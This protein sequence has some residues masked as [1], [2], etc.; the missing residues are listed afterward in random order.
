MAG[1]YI[2]KDGFA[3]VMLIS[4]KLLA[5]SS[6]V[7]VL[8]FMPVMPLAPQENER[9]VDMA[10]APGSKTTYF[11]A[12]MKNSVNQNMLGAFVVFYYA[13]MYIILSHVVYISL[14]CQSLPKVFGQ[15]TADRILLDAP[16]SGTGV[17]SKDE[18][19]KTSKTAAD[20]QNC[21][22]LQK[23]LILAAIDMV[24]ANSK[25]G[26]YIVYSTCSIMVD[27]NEAVID[28]ALKKRDVKLVSCGLDFG[29]PG[30]IRFMQHRFHTSLDKTRRFYPHVHNMDGFFVA[31]V[32]AVSF[33]DNLCCQ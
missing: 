27:E 29:R 15:N 8:S 6:K 9:V 10:A 11:A 13:L 30:F 5:Y 31:K 2:L 18:S 1:H 22:Q 12:L 3:P 20:I 24:D 33:G 17:I 23:E 28:Y 16:C 14:C 26:G 19:V 25:S 21:S 32:Y 4:N 7:R